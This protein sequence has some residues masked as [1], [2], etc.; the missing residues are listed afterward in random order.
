[1]KKVKTKRADYTT[2]TRQQRRR[3]QKQ[4]IAQAA[5]WPSWSALETALINGVVSPP[6]N[7]TP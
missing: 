1:M 4:A 7:P 3:Q 5:G 6:T 2:A